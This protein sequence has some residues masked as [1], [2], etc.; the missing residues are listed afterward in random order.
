[1]GELE[2]V[3]VLADSTSY[4]WLERPEVTGCEVV[5]RTIPGLRNP[6]Q[7]RLHVVAAL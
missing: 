7:V 6:A 1:M 4:G 2:V 3:V 5:V